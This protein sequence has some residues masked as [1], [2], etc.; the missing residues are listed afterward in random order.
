MKVKDKHPLPA[1]EQKGNFIAIKNGEEK[2][3][4]TY[5]EASVWMYGK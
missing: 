4:E 3:F 2:Y 5:R 1:F